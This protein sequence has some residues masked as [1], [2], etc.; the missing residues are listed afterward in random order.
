MAANVAIDRYRTAIG[1]LFHATME[2]LIQPVQ[3]EL[4]SVTEYP[5]S[6]SNTETFSLLFGGPAEPFLSQGIYLLEHAEI[7][8]ES[9]FLTATGPRDGGFTYEIIFSRIT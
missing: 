2:T 7:A 3:L 5:S 9:L 8:P 4:L 6:G 1:T